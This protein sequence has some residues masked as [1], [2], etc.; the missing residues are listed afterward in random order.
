M[1]T[2]PAAYLRRSY[3]DPNSPGDISLEAQRT[4]VRKLAAADGHNGNLIEYDDWGV[5]ADVAKSSKRTAYAR[6]LADM[7]A[8]NVAAVYAFDVDRLY[9]DPRDLIR[10][11]DAA[12]AHAVRIVTTGGTLAIGDGDDPAAE[13]FAFIGAVF[14]RME[15]QKAKKRARAA[16]EARMARGDRFG[17][18]PYGFQH[19]RD[20]SGRIVR[21]PDQARPIAPILAAYREAGTVLGTCRLLNERGI[22]SPKGG[23][24]YTSALTRVLETHAPELLPR[25]GASG[26]RIRASAILS[27]IVRCHCGHTM[28]PNTHR[29]QL[30]CSRGHV[31][32]GHGRY[33]VQ[34]KDLIPW[35]Q[36]EAA[37]LQVPADA[38][39]RASTDD[40]REAVMARL[41]RY[42]ELYAE[43]GDTGIS[44]E[45]Y[46]AEKARASAEI[47]DLEDEVIHSAIPQEIDWSKS[48]ASVNA[49]LRSMWRFVQLDADMRPVAAEW[50]KPEWRR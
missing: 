37:R 9:R 48:P 8:G 49:V 35:I 43:G 24:W 10:L 38:V 5:S 14:G 20:A 39:E 27:Q 15:L 22:P 25:R 33:T 31:E 17:H 1:N 12:Q 3:V 29:R 50:V 42:A 7:E 44:R 19:V 21:A 46:D 16:R 34:E 26:Q 36:A 40:R 30:Y 4:A 23:R 28:T 13:G 45:R 41:A 2:H 6:L 11:Q 47:A 18:P 32:S